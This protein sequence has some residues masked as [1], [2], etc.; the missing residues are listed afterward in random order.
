MALTELIKEMERRLL[1]SRHPDREEVTD[2][3]GDKEDA[4]GEA[5]GAP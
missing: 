4:V 1:V 2:H 3:A 5:E